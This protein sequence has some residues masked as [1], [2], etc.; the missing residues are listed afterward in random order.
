MKTFK[1]FSFIILQ[2][3]S[4]MSLPQNLLFGQTPPKL[5]CGG[6]TTVFTTSSGTV[7]P[8]NGPRICVTQS[9]N[10]TVSPTFTVTATASGT[11]YVAGSLSWT[12]EG[13]IVIVGGG[14]TPTVTARATTPTAL[15]QSWGKGRL[16]VEYTTLNGNCGCRGFASIDVYKT[17]TMGVLDNF[18]PANINTT[19]ASTLCVTPGSNISV[20][21]DPKYSRNIAASIGIDRYQWNS[22]AIPGA[23]FSG[24]N[25]SFFWAVPTNFTGSSVVTVIPGASCN[26]L[27]KRLTIS[28]GGGIGGL[29]GFEAVTAANGILAT[30]TNS[31]AN[32]WNNFTS[33][34][35][36]RSVCLNAQYGTTPNLNITNPDGYFR[37]TG[38]PGGASYAWTIPQGFDVVDNVTNAIIPNGPFTS[39]TI[40]VRPRGGANGSSGTFFCQVVSA[41]CGTSTSSFK[42]NRRLVRTYTDLSGQVVNFN[43]V[44]VRLVS[45]NALV[46]PLNNVGRSVC[47]TPAAQYRFTIL[48]FPGNTP[49]LWSQSLT[50][51][52]A[53]L[54]TGLSST[55]TNPII[56]TSPVNLGLNSVGAT[57]TDCSNRVDANT[58][59]QP[60]PGGTALPFNVWI[61]NNIT[62][63]AGTQQRW[64]HTIV[65]GASQPSPGLLANQSLS[66]NGTWP[67]STNCTGLDFRYTWRFVGRYTDQ[68]GV[69]RDYIGTETTNSVSNPSYVPTTDP[70]FFPVFQNFGNVRTISINPGTISALPGQIFP[71]IPGP[72]LFCRIERATPGAANCGLACFDVT[73]ATD[74]RTDQGGA[75]R[76]AVGGNNEPIELELDP[77]QKVFGDAK[78]K[79]FPN[80]SEGE[81]T[82]EKSMGIK[83]NKVNLMTAE[84]KIIRTIDLGNKTS[85]KVSGLKPGIYLISS[86]DNDSKPLPFVVR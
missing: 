59:V 69:N 66:T 30:N 77:Q 28:A 65:T 31:P 13:D 11:G 56:A 1:M 67:P 20:S 86:E 17:I 73:V 80:P 85:T 4:I 42:V 76:Q 72:R 32:G 55:T 48:N 5:E 8:S 82:I 6:T 44:E 84:G 83:N 2:V 18:F 25:S 62:G 29:I 27:E 61:Y 39:A 68:N 53:S 47:V 54:W 52:A 57:S 37:L 22:T 3:V 71:N 74:M 15:S 79:V 34:G 16:K 9:A 81:I 60:N 63:L 26:S 7:N 35:N 14:T 58:T 10:P 43:T 40:K 19:N 51:P 49:I 78:L 24:D 46:T 45:S 38:P 64:D 41:T 50:T 33:V 12:A 23:I 36:V 21:L 75:Y 70:N